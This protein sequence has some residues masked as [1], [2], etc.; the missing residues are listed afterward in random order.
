LLPVL[1]TVRTVQGDLGMRH[2]AGGVWAADR[3][4]LQG[5]L[6]VQ[7]ADDIGAREANAGLLPA[8]ARDAEVDRA[9]GI[10]C[11]TLALQRHCGRQYWEFRRN[12]PAQLHRT[13]PDLRSVEVLVGTG[14]VLALGPDGHRILEGALA[15]GQDKQELMAPGSPRIVLDRHYMLAAAGLLSTRDR[16][17]A[18]RFALS[19]LAV[20]PVSG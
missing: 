6:D 14:G 5:R 18:L 13:G 10:S 7:L 1:P 16:D 8:T 20:E 19:E 4:W 17:L 11:A 12:E 3:R 9:L 15:R 2:S